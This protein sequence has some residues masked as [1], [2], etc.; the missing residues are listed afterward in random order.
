ELFVRFLAR[1]PT[2]AELALG[3]E[4]MKAAAQDHAQATAKLAE[5]EK[6][7][8]EKQAAWEA[9]LGKP[10]EWTALV[11]SELKSAAGATLT[12]QDDQS[13]L[14]TGTLAKDTYTFVAP[15]ELK[16]ITGL[17]LEALADDSLPGK[18]PGR[19]QNGNFVLHELKVTIAS[20]ADPAQA[21]AV[22]LTNAS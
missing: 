22:E 11:P 16:G 8:P 14:A 6:L 17:R 1:K 10:V 5:Y 7:V 13:V 12:K 9:S 3:R 20:K 4:A 21:A 18:G 19:A 2:E 15:V